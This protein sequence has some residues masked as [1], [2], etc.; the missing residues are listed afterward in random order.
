MHIEKS[1]KP[2]NS[3]PGFLLLSILFRGYFFE[4]ILSAQVINSS[5]SSI[6]N[7]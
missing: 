7:A 6:E 5:A 3:L 2:G 4:S 1:G